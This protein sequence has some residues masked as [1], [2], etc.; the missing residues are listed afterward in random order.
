MPGVLAITLI[1]SG[2]IS[3]G[4]KYETRTHSIPS[5]C[6]KSGKSFSSNLKSPRSLPYEVEFSLTKRSS[7]T[8][9]SP[10]QA[11]SSKISPGSRETNEPRNAGIAQKVHLRSQPEA[12]FNGAQGVDSRRLRYTCGP[13]PGVETSSLANCLST[14]EIGSNFLLSP[15]VCGTILSPAR[16]FRSVEPISA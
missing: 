5:G 13:M 16:T 15:G 9:F 6:T 2:R 8:P 11:A 3:A 4:C 10:S 12:I 14:G 7:R 1:R